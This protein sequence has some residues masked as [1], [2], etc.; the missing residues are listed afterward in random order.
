MSEVQLDPAVQAER[1]RCLKC[2]ENCFDLPIRDP[3]VLAILF[4][5]TTMIRTGMQAS[6]SPKVDFFE[7]RAL[8]D[9]D[10]VYF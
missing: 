9:T 6:E 4:K 10:P 1:T 5:I 7:Q 8:D 2:V 3:L